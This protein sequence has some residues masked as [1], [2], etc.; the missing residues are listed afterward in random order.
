MLSCARASHPTTRSSTALVSKCA[1]IDGASF[2]SSRSSGANAIAD[3]SEDSLLPGL[4]EKQVEE[5]RRSY[6]VKMDD[7][8]TLEDSIGDL[9]DSTTSM[10]NASLSASAHD[11]GGR[12]DPPQGE[13]SSQPQLP[14]RH[15]HQS[16]FFQETLLVEETMAFMDIIICSLVAALVAFQYHDIIQTC[17]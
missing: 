9:S 13:E 7:T 4:D 3:L 10:V 11:H 1:A 17:S 2:L 5:A 16:P 6:T 14:H 8:I 15:H 12:L